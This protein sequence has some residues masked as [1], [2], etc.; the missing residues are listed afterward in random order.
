RE[1][2]VASA[3]PVP[4]LVQAPLHV[5]AIGVP[6]PTELNKLHGTDPTLGENVQT[7]VIDATET[8]W[9]DGHEDWLRHVTPRVTKVVVDGVDDKHLAAMR[10]RA[11]HWTPQGPGLQCAV[12]RRDHA[13]MDDDPSDDFP[14]YLRYAP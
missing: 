5:E 6:L 14:S 7:L 9:T 10:A 12:E 13:A 3:R 11:A 2:R 8:T 4:F 1:Q